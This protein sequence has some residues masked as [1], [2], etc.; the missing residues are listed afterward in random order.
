VI[1]INSENN[2][3]NSDELDITNFARYPQKKIKK[4]LSKEDIKI[5]KKQTTSVNDD[6]GIV[7]ESCFD[8]INPKSAH[9]IAAD[10]FD[11]LIIKEILQEP[12]IQTFEISMKLNIPLSIVHKK[13]RLIESS[14]LTKKYI[15]DLIKLGINLRFA[16]IFAEIR[17]D[18]VTDFVKKLYSTSLR[19]NMLS[20]S[21]VK[22]D[23][24]GICIKAAY[25]HSSELFFLMDTLKSY[26][27]IS[28]IH[29]SEE[30]EV[31]EDNTLAVILN[32]IN[33]SY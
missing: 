2:D 24:N 13:R 17:E 28:N 21:R 1:E 26:P 10:R 25:Q 11:L 3:I 29:F 14:L 18:K 4:I 8:Y 31:I 15:V 6:S 33:G 16:D 19:K 9:F 32:L 30:I 5:A 7:D 27:F 12:N 23:S 22:N 20:I